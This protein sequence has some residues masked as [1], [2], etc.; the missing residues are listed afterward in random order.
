MSSFTCLWYTLRC[1]TLCVCPQSSAFGAPDDDLF[2]SLSGPTFG[3]S[4]PQAAATASVPAAAS[5]RPKRTWWCLACFGTQMVYAWG[6]MPGA[7]L[8]VVSKYAEA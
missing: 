6:D 8:A 5:S 1:D 3:S 2:G 4:K 7:P